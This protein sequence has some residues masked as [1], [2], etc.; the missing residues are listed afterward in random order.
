MSFTCYPLCMNTKKAVDDFINYL[1]HEKARNPLTV[2]NY[3]AYLHR[4]IAISKTSDV[5][6]ISTESIKR[7]KAVLIKKGLST[8][9]INY[10]LICLRLFLRF[11][12]KQD[13][14]ALSPDKV[15]TFSKAPDRKIELIDRKSVV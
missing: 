5:S 4:F 14:P 2:R 11:L 1:V 9:T 15:E 7:F 13:V 8:K 6:N 10:Y 3:T 12:A